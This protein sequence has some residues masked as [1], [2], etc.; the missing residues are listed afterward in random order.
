M[1]DRGPDLFRC[2]SCFSIFC[3]PG[4]FWIFG[5]K[6]V[7]GVPKSPQMP[8]TEAE[9]VSE[10]GSYAGVDQGQNMANDDAGGIAE[11]RILDELQLDQVGEASS[12][13][14]GQL[15]QPSNYPGI[16]E[17][18]LPEPQKP[19][20][21][22]MLILP[23]EKPESLPVKATD[24]AASHGILTG[25][26]EGLTIP[27]PSSD[28]FAVP[29]KSQPEMDQKVDAEEQDETA[30][31]DTVIQMPEGHIQPVIS[32]TTPDSDV[33]SPGT[34]ALQQAEM[35][36]LTA[37]PDDAEVGGVP[38]LDILKAIVYGGLLESI[39]SLSVVTSAVGA[40]ASTLNV[41]ALGVANLI[42]GLFVLAHNLRVLKH[43]TSVERYESQ[44]GR[45][46]YFPI[47]AT[48]AV[49]SYL[50]FGLLPPI[51]YAFSFRESNNRDLKLVT[52]ASSSLLCI[53]LLALGKAYARSPPK[54]YIKTLAYYV[55]LGI[56]VSGASLIIGD[57]VK[58]LMDKLGWFE[59]SYSLIMLAA[60][61]GSSIKTA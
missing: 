35:A 39:T 11:P 37:A 59:S 31:K 41:L 28:A 26:E 52:L 43:E 3:P 47:H 42:G 17:D 27:I 5:D 61:D 7:D 19:E 48:F 4:K 50:V 20:K 32:P 9:K 30:G 36:T 1:E 14:V 6:K 29:D 8:T 10:A 56:T 46:G 53:I 25:Q 44:L 24:E 60:K 33:V 51:I 12:D 2:L 34:G 18:V 23:A 38:L 22:T 49:L 57:L 58:L 21:P 55:S 16:A 54:Y 15:D 45:I 13:Q 40:D